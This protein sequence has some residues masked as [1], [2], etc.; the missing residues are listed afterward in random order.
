MTRSHPGRDALRPSLIGRQPIYNREGSVFAYE[1]LFRD[2]ALSVQDVDPD[3]ATAQVLDTFLMA[4]G[5]RRLTGGKKAFINFPPAF[6]E[7][8]FQPPAFGPQTIVIEIL[9]T[10]PATEKV[11]QTLRALKRMGY[12]LALDDFVLKSEHQS[13]LN[14]ADIIKVEI[15]GLTPQQIR[16]VAKT[17]RKYTDAAL[18]AEKVETPEIHRACLDGGYDYFQGYFYA[19]PV[20]LKT[21][22][23]EASK[24]VLLQL[25]GRINNPNAHLQ[26]LAGLVGN[27]PGLSSRLLLL[28]NQQNT[29]SAQDLHF[30]SIFQVLHFFGINR[31]KAWVSMIS[32]AQFEDLDPEVLRLALIRAHFMARSAAENGEDEDSYYLAGLLSKL[33]VITQVDMATLLQ[34]MPLDEALKLALLEKQGPMGQLLLSVEKMEQNKGDTLPSSLQQRY[35]ES[36]VSANEEFHELMSAAAATE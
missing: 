25:L 34:Q 4:N 19:K 7:G 21:E 22:T 3:R 10:V 35:L 9:E 33:D 27:D 13:L 11:M 8:P 36:V 17:V 6:F 20:T 12:T 5:V 14:L 1:F 26:E 30:H 28:A 32:L 29:D 15:L 23:I 16:H 2:H 24:L 31:V 18:L